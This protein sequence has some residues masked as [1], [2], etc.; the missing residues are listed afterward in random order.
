M[1]LL[2]PDS[3]HNREVGVFQIKAEAIS[4]SG[5]TIAS[6]TQP[7]MLRYKSSPVR[8]A[9]ATLMWVPLTMGIRSES[10]TATLEMFHY[11]EGHGRH[12]KTGLIR[13][14]LQ[15]RAMTVHL[16]QVYRAEIIVQTS[17]P[18]AKELVRRLKWT[19]CVW[20]SLSV[21]AVLLVLAVCWVRPVAFFAWGR[22][23]S[24]HQ[25]N[26]KTISSLGRRDFGE[27]SNK[28][29]SG[30]ALV[31]W[32]ERRSKR[33]ARFGTLHG[34]RVELKFAEDSASSAAVVET[35]EVIDDP[36]EFGC[37]QSSVPEFN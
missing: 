15:P 7:Y 35:A 5:N 9:Q 1:A 20:V 24:D 18:W 19:V 14:L 34:G 21:Y 26:G 11:R 29:L 2:L 10:Q 27:N 12:K 28:E 6:T 13:V 22:R 30:G 4:P 32:R 37:A 23:L 25:V 36:G 17:L 31:K 33:K 8:L 16:P 3:Y